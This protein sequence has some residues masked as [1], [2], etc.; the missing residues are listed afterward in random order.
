LTDVN[1]QVASA[2]RSVRLE[3]RWRPGSAIRHLRKRRLRG[4]LP[5]DATIEEYDRIIQRI[6]QDPDAQVYV[7]WHGDVSY[8]AIVAIVQHSSWL[9]MFD[10]D[11]VLETAYVVERPDRYLNKSVFQRLGSVH[12]VVE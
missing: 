7:Y 5:P 3:V 2:I 9:V 12:E 1:A 11:G 8:V 4:H 10:L 6:L